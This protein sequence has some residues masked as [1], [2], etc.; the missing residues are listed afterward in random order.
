[1]TYKTVHPFSFNDR[2]FLAAALVAFMCGASICSGVA[3]AHG[4]TE[5]N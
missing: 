4:A 3:Q 1:M 5:P 2:A